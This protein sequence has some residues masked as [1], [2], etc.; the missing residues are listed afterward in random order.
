M[1]KLKAYIVDGRA[2]TSVDP[3]GGDEL[4][5]NLKLKTGAKNKYVNISGSGA[6]LVRQ[7]KIVNNEKIQKFRFPLP[8]ESE[9]RHHNFS[10]SVDDTDI[11]ACTYF[12]SNSR[13]LEVE[14]KTDKPKK[15]TRSKQTTL[16]FG[17]NSP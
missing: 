11:L 14:K 13:P 15:N 12:A 4:N 1:E 2:I 7:I 16:V 3:R 5:L 9:G 6:C 10:I 8:L 17:M